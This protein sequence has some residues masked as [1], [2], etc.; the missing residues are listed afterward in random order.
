MKNIR[1]TIENYGPD[2][3][4]WPKDR[5][6]AQ[7][8]S[9]LILHQGRYDVL[10]GWRTKYYD[11]HGYQMMPYVVISRYEPT[12]PKAWAKRL[13]KERRFD[14]QLPVSALSLL[15]GGVR[16]EDA[17]AARDN[18]KKLP[19]T[20]TGEF[21][22]VGDGLDAR[23]YLYRSQLDYTLA[24]Q[25]ILSPWDAILRQGWAWFYFGEA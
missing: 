9:W 16:W 10:S 14:G 12:L 15:L 18:A 17:L 5:K 19:V 3:A 6:A 8:A 24:P 21:Y 20:Y 25:S 4:I 23:H 7:L 1:V 22:I 11:K 2:I 13:E